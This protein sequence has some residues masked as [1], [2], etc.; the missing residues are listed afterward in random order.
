MCG[1]FILNYNLSGLSSRAR[2]RLQ[3][4]PFRQKPDLAIWVPS[5]D[6]KQRTE[7]LQGRE[8]THRPGSCGSER[9]KVYSVPRNGRSVPDVWRHSG[10][11]FRFLSQ[12]VGEVWGK[13]RGGPSR[14]GYHLSLRQSSSS[15]INSQLHSE[16]TF[17]KERRSAVRHRAHCEGDLA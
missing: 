11:K 15:K 12:V 13:D 9:Y 3:Q 4:N 1:P 6:M 16:P 7:Q 14:S 5:Y 10:A 8:K 2:P 17:R